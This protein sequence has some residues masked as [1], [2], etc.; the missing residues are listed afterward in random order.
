MHRGAFPGRGSNGGGKE[1][2]DKERQ[3]ADAPKE[4]WG[5]A[6]LARADGGPGRGREPAG[7]GRCAPWCDRGGRRHVPRRLPGPGRRALARPRGAADREGRPHPVPA[8][9]LRDAR[10]AARRRHRQARP[11]RRSDRRG[12]RRGGWLVDTQ[13]GSPSRRCARARRPFD[14]RPGP[15]RPRGRLQDPGPQHRESS[16]HPGEGAGGDPDGAGAG[17]RRIRAGRSRISRSS[18]RNPPC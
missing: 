8:R 18:S 2:H 3:D 17:A 16:Q 9:S 12:A 7:Q 11:F 10:R 4:D 14:R 15:P 6:G 1:E 5:R 13:R